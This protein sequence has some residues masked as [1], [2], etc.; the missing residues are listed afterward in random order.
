MFDTLRILVVL[1]MY[2]GSLPIGC[3][4]AKALTDLG[5]V[6]E[7]F[8]APE[9]HTAFKA[10][11]SVGM[12]SERL[13]YLENSYLQLVGQAILAKV[14]EF[15]PDLV[16]AMAQAPLSR[17]TLRRLQKDGVTTAMWF[18]EDYQLFTYWQ[19]FAP[20]YDIFA[21]IQK[22]RI[23]EELAAIGQ[24]NAM[25][26]PLAADPDFHTPLELSPVERRKWGSDVGFMGAGYPNRRAAFCRLL[27][28][29]FKIWGNDWEGD[30]I[31]R[32]AIQLE[33]RRVS[34]EECVK[35]FN[36]TRINLNLHSSVNPTKLV[37]GGDFVN[38]RTFELAAC[39]AFQL[40]DERSLMAEHFAPDELA[41]FT[42]IDGLLASVDHFLARPEE[43][44]AFAARARDRV[45]AEHTYTAR[46]QSL[47][48]FVAGRKA[49]WPKAKASRDALKELPEELRGEVA[50][51][52]QRLH[53]RQDVSF[54][55]LVVAVRRQSCT[56]S[57]V[58]TAV[59]FLDEWRKQYC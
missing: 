38:P 51:L 40:V 20:L 14:E 39:G 10:F 24:P 55:D 48:E 29:D 58:E 52:L 19:T 28:R 46:M 43:R 35:I 8:E 6:A 30:E 45:L 50:G 42:S 44:M 56:L 1:P 31:L 59:L 41:T 23:F 32:P 2:G 36:A 11:R 21:V 17:Q 16:L 4:A 27:D 25:Y 54:D 33:G 3:F 49:G 18:V 26:L 47:L 5:H 15:S 7:T 9:F 12:A 53:L 34:S 57:E 22:G 37:S 13:D